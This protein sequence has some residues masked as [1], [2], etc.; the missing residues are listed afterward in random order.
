MTEDG[1]KTST[2]RADG[3]ISDARARGSTT[4]E[5]V[6]SGQGLTLFDAPALSA[7][8]ERAHA[9]KN[10]LSVIIAVARLVEGE[11]SG[12][13]RERMARLEAA[14]LRLRDLLADDLD[15]K[16]TSA[17]GRDGFRTS[18]VASLA[19]DVTARLTDRAE[20]SQVR[21]STRC[22]GGQLAGDEPKLKEALFN[23]VANAIEATPAGGR[24]LVTTQVTADEDHVWTL[25]DTGS[26]IAAEQL[27]TL[28]LPYSTRRPGGSGLGLA[29]AR[30]VAAEH[31]GLVRIESVPGAGTV[32]SLWLPRDHHAT[33]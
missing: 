22:A 6:G 2:T 13:G 15:E 9:M 31:G 20:H 11:L 18:C 8:A 16:P 12:R 4:T 23:L 27:A 14:S 21:V 10:C 1:K 17:E 33:D 5:S 29:F 19:R 30:K 24:V 28:G 32:V 7:R 25:Q 3:A 26:G